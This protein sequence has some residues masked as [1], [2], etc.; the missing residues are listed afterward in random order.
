MKR[1]D[2]LVPLSRDHHEALMLCL[3][4]HRGLPARGGDLEWVASKARQVAAFFESHL[5]RHFRSEE[6]GVFPKLKGIEDA[7][8]LIAELLSEHRRLEKLVEALRDC[9][10]E[11]TASLLSNFADLLESH[12][13]KEER[14]LFPLYERYVTAD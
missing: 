2:S 8:V 5:V 12:I 13:R 3:R 7:S 4:I 11:E 1:H 9:K 6:E 14:V 10:R